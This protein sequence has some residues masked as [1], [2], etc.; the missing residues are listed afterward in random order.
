MRAAG[1]RDASSSPPPGSAAATATTPPAPTSV[2]GGAVTGFTKALARERE[3]ALVKAVDFAAPSRKTAALADL[4]IEETLRDPGAVEVGHADEL[5]WTVG[6]VERPAQARPGPPPPRSATTCSSS[7]A[8]PAASSRRSPPT[9]PPRSRRHLPPA[10]PRRRARPRRPRPRAL[11]RRPRRAQA[12]AGR[13][14]QASA[15]RSPR[16]SSSSASWRGIERARAAL[17]AMQAIERRRRHGALAPGRPHRRRSRSAPPSR[18]CAST[19]ASTCCC[20]APGWRSATSCR[21]SRR[22]EYDLVFDVKADGWFNLL[23][24]L[25]RRRRSAPRSPSARSPG[26]SA[27]RGQTDYSAAN[28]LLCKSISNLR[29][30]G[31]HARHRDRLDG[32]G[33]A[34]AWPPAARSRR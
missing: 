27:T 26:A 1:R 23:R 28:D 7:P 10:R 22:R 19:A 21:T 15:A 20:T 9:S 31:R 11:R 30:T 24:A 3:G 8:P 17:D 14:L 6:L 4:L 13:A 2:M 33:G 16:P 18:R 5:R 34:S 32:V 12:R 25:R 29:R